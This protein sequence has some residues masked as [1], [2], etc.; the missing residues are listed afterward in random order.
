MKV[1]ITTGDR[2]TPK[3]ILY[4]YEMMLE[5][6]TINIWAYNLETILAEKLETIIVRGVANTRMRDFYDLY[7]LYK[8]YSEKIDPVLLAEAVL[9]TAD[10]RNSTDEIKKALN[11][12]LQIENDNEMKILWTRYQNSFSYAKE[13]EWIDIMPVIRSLWNIISNALPVS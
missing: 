7:V 4:S 11:V 5:K 13:I 3:E 9:K 6:R 2:I 1:D 8:T 12:F 10:S